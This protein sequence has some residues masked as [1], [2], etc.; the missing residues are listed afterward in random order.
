MRFGT[1]ILLWVAVVLAAMTAHMA[2]A[3]DPA[4]VQPAFVQVQLHAAYE[5]VLDI[6]W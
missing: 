1:L 5:D 3:E 2:L 4:P 6:F